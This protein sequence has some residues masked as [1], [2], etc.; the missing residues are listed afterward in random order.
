M[1]ARLRLF[2]GTINQVGLQNRTVNAIRF[3]QYEVRLDLKQSLVSKK[4]ERKNRKAMSL[5]EMRAYIREH[6]GDGGSKVNK[7][8]LEMHGKFS[9]PFSCLVLGLVAI[10]LGARSEKA[11]RSMGL[12]LGLAEFVIYYLIMT[13]GQVMAEMGRLPA[14]AACW[15]P[16][17]VM[18]IAGVLLL[19]LSARETS[20]LPGGL[21]RIL[22]SLGR[23]FRIWER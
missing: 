9:I 11:R 1:I 18:G 21:T 14:A 4:G 15:L 2:D 23:L 6:G 17:A 7:I 8:R 5:K 13:Y 20:L 16:N 22:T 3:Q 12:I 19:F 10:P